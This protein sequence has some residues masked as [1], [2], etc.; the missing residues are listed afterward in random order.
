MEKGA[1]H[2]IHHGFAIG[3]AALGD[4]PRTS[5]ILKGPSRFDANFLLWPKFRL[6]ASNQTLLPS[7]NGTKSVFM[8]EA[9]L[10]QASS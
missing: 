8:Q 6:V 4:G 5:L 1:P 7:S 9:I 2:E 3:L 10:F